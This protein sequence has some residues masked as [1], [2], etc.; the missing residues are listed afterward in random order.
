MS[1]RSDSDVIPALDAIAGTVTAKPEAA[2]PGGRAERPRAPTTLGALE[3]KIE[4][5]G[6]PIAEKPSEDA[7]TGDFA[8]AFSPEE[9]K[10]TALYAPAVGTL[11]D[12]LEEPE[13]APEVNPHLVRLR[14]QL[15]HL[16]A[17]HADL[18]AHLDPGDGIRGPILAKARTAVAETA[19]LIEGLPAPDPDAETPTS[20][21]EREE[22]E[23]LE[24]AKQLLLT[25]RFAL[26]E[27]IASCR[28]APEP[29]PP[30]P[31]ARETREASAPAPRPEAVLDDEARG[32]RRLI[33]LGVLVGLLAAGRVGLFLNEG[34]KGAAAVLEEK[35]E[36]GK[37]QTTNRSA[38][39][40]AEQL[41]AGIPSVLEIR[42]AQA[43]DGS[44]QARAVAIDPDGDPVSIT[45]RWLEGDQQVELEGR[46]V[47]GAHRVRAGARYR[48]EA[49]ASDGKRDGEPVVSPVLVAGGAR[50]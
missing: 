21:A 12:R 50:P 27:L 38:G 44:L 11:I 14:L 32:R 47:L 3:V 10:A 8:P 2:R 18:K 13:V 46:G 5:S 42:L 9:V 30:E 36:A 33:A 1:N 20:D 22:R 45:Y 6:P 24:R 48:V 31:V 41:E 26:E 29:P 49:R 19:E 4:V 43:A 39:A 17:V 7:P 25:A 40:T 15:P 37:V 34:R 28:T 23:E 35:Q 16:K